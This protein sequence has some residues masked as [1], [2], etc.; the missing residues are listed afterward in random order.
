[1]PE[2]GDMSAYYA[3]KENLKDLLKEH[4]N[5]KFVVTGHSLGGALAI[6]VTHEEEVMQSLFGVYT[7]GHQ[8][9][10]GEVHGSSFG[11]SNT[12]VLQGGLLQ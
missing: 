7:F 5:A 9:S 4:K 10:A 12:K 8:G 6:L 3:V 1:M 2:M 11:F